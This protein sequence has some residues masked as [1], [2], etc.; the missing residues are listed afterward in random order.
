MIKAFKRV[1]PKKAKKSRPL[2]QDFFVLINAPTRPSNHIERALGTDGNA[3]RLR[4][5]MNIDRHP[6]L[7]FFF[8]FSTP[9]PS[10]HHDA[11]GTR[12]CVN[13]EADSGEH[14]GQEDTAVR[15]LGCRTLEGYRT[16]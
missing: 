14:H 13:N 3:D 6:S 16:G 8:F 9:P 4:K 11:K 1:S 7:L 10:R 5:D 2:T 15:G 12:L